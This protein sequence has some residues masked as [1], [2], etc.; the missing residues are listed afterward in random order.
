MFIYLL[1][2][3]A[4]GKEYIGKTVKSLRMRL[5][6]HKSRA[7]AG[8]DY[9]ISRAIREH[10]VEVFDMVLLATAESHDELWRLEQHYIEERQ[11]LVPNGFNLVRGGKGNYGWTPSEAT[12]R[13]ISEAMIG[14]VGWNK[15]LAMSEEVRRAMSLTRKGKPQ[16]AAQKEARGKAMTDE[17]RAKISA[18]KTGVP[19]PDGCR[20]KWSTVAKRNHAAMSP[21]KKRLRAQRIS[22]TKK[23]RGQEARERRASALST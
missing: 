10:G 4:S 9:P 2:H 8:A 13:R 22:A 19:L 23:L 15:G 18:S 12:R 17:V 1:R 20:A 21:E 5:Y 6:G 3:R 16:T 14:R 11:T 7:M